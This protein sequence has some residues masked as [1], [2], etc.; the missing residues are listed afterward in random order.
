VE[1]ARHMYMTIHL[2]LGQAAEG[3]QPS[4]QQRKRSGCFT[5]TEVTIDRDD[6]TC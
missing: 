1:I 4:L 6:K 3:K 2:S 5:A